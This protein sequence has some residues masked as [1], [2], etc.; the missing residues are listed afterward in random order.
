MSRE[1]YQVGDRVVEAEV[2][3]KGE[4]ISVRTDAGVV[5]VEVRRLADGRWWLRGPSGSAVSLVSGDEV[6]IG[7]QV[8][9]VRRA[10]P[11]AAAPPPVVTPPMPGVVGRVLVAVRDRVV[12]RQPVMTVTAMKMELTLRAPRDGVVRAVRAAPGDRVG[13]GDVLVEVEP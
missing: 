8:R 5:E 10:P 3:A 11:T 1:R 13:P 7:G 12:A 2:D 9:R 4:R 6:A